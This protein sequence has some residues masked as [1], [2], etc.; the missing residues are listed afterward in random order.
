MHH[1]SHITE[2]VGGFIILLLFAAGTL[3]ASQRIKLPYS[4]ALVLAGMLLSYL[5]TTYPEQLHLIKALELSP[6]LILFVFL[7]TLIFESTFNLDT[8]QLRHNIDE[9]LSLAIPGL[10]LSTLLIGLIVW[11][12]TPIPFPASLLLGAIL[13]AT[14]PVS[15]VATFKQLGAPQRLTILVEGESLFNDATAIV[16]ARILIGVVAAG[17]VSTETV[18][19]GIADFFI[20]FVGGLLVG[21]AL[22]RLTGFLLGL[23]ESDAYIEISL[24]TILAYLSFILAEEVLG[25]SGVMATMGA[26]LSMAGR[27]RMKISPSVRSYLEHFWEYMAFIANA[28]IFLMVGLRVE[29]YAVWQNLD[30]LPWVIIG[31]LLARAALIYGMMPLVGRLPGSTPISLR[32]QTV[33]FWGGQRGAIALAIVLSLPVFEYSDVF[34]ALVMGSVLFTLLVQGLTIE[35]LVR[36]LGLDQPPLSDRLSVLERNVVARQRVLKEIPGLLANGL[37]SGRIARHLQRDCEREINKAEQDIRDLRNHEM[38]ITRQLNL[39]Y[40]RVF[41]EEKSLYIDMYN[42]GHL[43][44]AAFRKLM[45]IL[46]SQIDA[47]RFHGQFQHMHFNRM[48]YLADQ[49]LPAII[50]HFPGI[51]LLAEKVHLA[52]VARDYELDWG[53]YQGTLHVLTFLTD[54]A[55]FE[56]LPEA[57]VTEVKRHYQHWHTHARERVEQMAELYPEFVSS[58]Q[59][60]LG[61]RMVLLA[62]AEATEQQV[63]QGTLPRGV[64]ESMQTDIQH[65]L[66]TLRGQEITPLKVDPTELLRKVPFFQQIPAAE[67]SH[68]AQRMRA[69]TFAADEVIIRQG[70]SGDSLFLIAR[71]VIHISQRDEHGEDTSLGTLMAG[72]FFGEMALLFHERRNA[73]LSAV[74]PCSLYE[75]PRSELDLAMDKFSVIRETLERVAKERKEQ[76]PA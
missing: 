68:L 28:M 72:D 33:M 11:L 57:V 59:E 6:E 45:L 9:V 61:R 25:V 20:L 63:E 52:R 7:P 50:R 8:A 27:G 14:D 40:L 58:M 15:V 55:Q 41:A 70:E 37:F 34:V 29:L 31:M 51:N 32:Y 30:L 35:P 53:H 56:S 4:V 47:L 21:W 69:H 54:Y 48:Q 10:L 1:A 17:T 60:R 16:V 65:R 22:A 46:T 5:A 13:S 67:F 18:T 43:S 26:G 12:A 75:L 44:E 49:A 2:L 76:N 38:D 3:A 74:T 62:E 71:G 66:A 24:T 73:T 39:L 23:V 42:K 36:R 19:S 64:A